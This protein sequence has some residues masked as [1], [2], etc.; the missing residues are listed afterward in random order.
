[1]NLLVTV[2]GGRSSAFMAYHIHTSPK[3]K[4]YNKLYV[5]C[6]TGMERPQTIDFLKKIESIWGIQ[7]TLIE[8]T[9]SN[10]LGIGVGY[11]IVSWDTLDMKAT[12]F[13]ESIMH[14]NKGTFNGLPNQEAPYCSSRMKVRPSE[15]FADEIFGKKNYLKAIGF[16]KED[17]PKRISWAEIKEDDKRIFP[18][19]TDFTEPIGLIELNKFWEFQPF[20]LE[21]SSKLGN[22]ELCWKKSDKVLIDSIRYGSRFIEWYQ[23]MEEKYGNTSF[24]NHRSI[25]DFVKMAENPFT[26]EI[27]FGQEDFNCICN[28]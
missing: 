22:C 4:D 1:M 26:P 9:Y 5:F 6:N 13:T 24:R 27:N 8:G 12:P 21:I 10:V 16:R 28:F 20:K 25:N 2:S 23:N 18:L 11:K 7:L 15:K 3:Y 17:M 19:I 14:A